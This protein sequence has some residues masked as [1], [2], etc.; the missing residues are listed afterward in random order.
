MH[1]MPR[2]GRAVG[3]SKHHDFDGKHG[4]G[5]ASE[6]A[7][8]TVNHSLADGSLQAQPATRACNPSLQ[9]EAAT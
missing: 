7:F 5:A 4:G 2:V 9:P 1:L 6:S 8:R 3:H